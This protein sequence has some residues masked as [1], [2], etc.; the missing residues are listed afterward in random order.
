MA[1]YLRFDVQAINDLTVESVRRFNEAVPDAPGV[2]YF[3]IT[4]SRPWNRVPAFAFHPWRVIQKAEGDNDGLVSVQSAMW[5]KHLATW[6]LDHWHQ[7]NRRR[8]AIERNGIGNVTP[9]YLRLLDEVQNAMTVALKVDIIHRMRRFRPWVF[10]SCAALSA[11]ACSTIIWQGAS[12]YSSDSSVMLRVTASSPPVKF[13][14]PM[15]RAAVEFTK[16][17]WTVPS[18]EHLR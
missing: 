16:S 6:P 8:Y 18:P 1:R 4:A 11:I 7:I 12:A 13:R 2:R 17:N 15:R 10:N 5:G 9:M 3:S 14:S